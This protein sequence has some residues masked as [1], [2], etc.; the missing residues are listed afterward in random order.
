MILR[1]VAL[2]DGQE[3]EWET[4]RRGNKGVSLCEQQTIISNIKEVG[5]REQPTRVSNTNYDDACLKVET[6]NRDSS[7]ERPWASPCSY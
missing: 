2:A 3:I 4:I 1:I 7:Q 6:E 5:F